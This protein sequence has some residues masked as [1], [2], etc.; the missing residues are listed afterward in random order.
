M[1]FTKTR[2]QSP[3]FFDRLATDGPPPISEQLKAEFAR[4]EEAFFLN[5]IRVKFGSPFA[6]NCLES[7]PRPCSY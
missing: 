5:R 4:R 6:R 3:S 7:E 1:V 2:G